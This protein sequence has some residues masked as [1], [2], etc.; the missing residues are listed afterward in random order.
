[1][2]DGR[3]QPM[4]CAI[5]ALIIFREV[6]LVDFFFSVNRNPSRRVRKASLNWGAQDLVR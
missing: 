4:L 3:H 2:P 1:M 6:V 5:I